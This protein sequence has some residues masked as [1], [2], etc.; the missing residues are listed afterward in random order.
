MRRVDMIF[1]N[2]CAEFFSVFLNVTSFHER[3][4]RLIVLQLNTFVMR[5]QSQKS[6]ISSIGT[7]FMYTI[8]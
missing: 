7:K 4:S 6:I 2:R 5:G 1:G 8:Y 3:L